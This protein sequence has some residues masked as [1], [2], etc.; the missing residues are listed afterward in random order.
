MRLVADY[1]HD[2]ASQRL[3]ASS[4]L[5]AERYRCGR[6]PLSGRASRPSAVYADQGDR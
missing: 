3:T 2:P 6:V 4:Q 5:I 1:G